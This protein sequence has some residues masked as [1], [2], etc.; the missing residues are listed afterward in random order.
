[1]RKLPKSQDGK[2]NGRLF[3]NWTRL[4]QRQ[5]REITEVK[6]MEG[7]KKKLLHT[8]KKELEIN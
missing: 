1:M 7:S 8:E 2:V 3:G 5:L 6:T 4:K